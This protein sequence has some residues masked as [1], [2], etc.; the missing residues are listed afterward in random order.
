MV[1]QMSGSRGDG[2]PWPQPGGTLTV[3]EDE[4]R[5]LCSTA[6]GSPIAVPVAREER[7]TE[8]GDAPESPRTEARDAPAPAAAPA[9]KAARAPSGPASKTK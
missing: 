1:Q 4:A 3:S 5:V 9:A 6:S 2:Q 7:R 8:T